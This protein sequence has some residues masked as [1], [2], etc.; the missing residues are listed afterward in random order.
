MEDP[1]RRTMLPII[2]V[3]TL[4]AGTL[5][6]S[7]SAVAAN[8][9]SVH[10]KLTTETVETGNLKFS[11]SWSGP[12]S[13][14]P[15]TYASW[16]NFTESIGA[17]L[18]AGGS[19]A[20]IIALGDRLALASTPDQ[21]ATLI[22]APNDRDFAS[23]ETT[24]LTLDRDEL[25]VQLDYTFKTATRV[26]MRPLAFIDDLLGSLLSGGSGFTTSIT[27]ITSDEVH[28]ETSRF[29][30]NHIRT[31]EGERIGGTGPGMSYLD[32]QRATYNT[33]SDHLTLHV[34]E[35][36]FAPNLMLGLLLLLFIITLGFCK[37]MG[38]E[39][40]GGFGFVILAAILFILVSLPRAEH[41]FLAVL[42]LGLFKQILKLRSF[43]R[44]RLFK[45][46][47]KQD[48]LASLGE[49]PMAQE[50]AGLAELDGSGNLM[51]RLF[52]FKITE[53]FMIYNDGRLISHA[54]LK[55]GGTVDSQI[56]SNMLTAIQDFI[57]ESFKTGEDES[58]E[59][60]KYGKTHLFIQRGKHVY[61]AAVIDGN[62]PDSFSKE[63]KDLVLE[64]EDDYRSL[65][66]DWDGETT[67]L[68]PA[69]ADMDKFIKYWSK[70]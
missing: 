51:A 5:M 57:S 56:V 4:L 36:P 52:P 2:L 12:L 10:L 59:T 50:K 7:G 15:I 1:R 24:R 60:I 3:L 69:K 62:A 31:H 40:L 34:V 38:K 44:R 21:A 25:V 18:R 27:A 65:I 39:G 64:L 35:S 41:L 19:Q 22:L 67:K 63:L 13:V 11:V 45:H 48:M 23:V 49:A 66:I 43:R 37:M 42:A 46:V 68:N 20:Q 55:V 61:L 53:L 32:S 70:S 30:L 14:G 54:T 16:S 8:E 28:L 58:L 29:L 33:T 6:G 26:K 47:D 9:P 17:D